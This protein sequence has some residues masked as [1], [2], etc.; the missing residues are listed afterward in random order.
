MNKTKSLLIIAILALPMLSVA[1]TPSYSAPT[2]EVWPLVGV[3]DVANVFYVSG[4][5]FDP[6]A[7]LYL[8]VGSLGYTASYDDVYL[9]AP[10]WPTGDFEAHVPAKARTNGAI[11][12]FAFGVVDGTVFTSESDQIVVAHTEL[13]PASADRAG[14][15]ISVIT[16][17][18]APFLTLV[19]PD[20]DITIFHVGDTITIKG[21]GFT[22]EGQVEIYWNNPNNL[23]ATTTADGSGKISV[24]VTVP[25][26]PSGYM[27]LLV[28]DVEAG[29]LAL[30]VYGEQTWTLIMVEPSIENTELSIDGSTTQ[31]FGVI[32]HGFAAINPDGQDGTPVDKAYQPGI[33]E[34]DSIELYD[35]WV[36]VTTEHSS[37]TASPNGL[38][39]ISRVRLDE[40]LYMPGWV[41]EIVPWWVNTFAGQEYP[42]YVVYFLDDYVYGW[43]LFSDPGQHEM[44]SFIKGTIEDYESGYVGDTFHIWIWNFPAN[45]AV[46]V[47]FGG[48]T[49][50]TVINTD[51]NGAGTGTFEVPEQPGGEYVVRAFVNGQYAYLTFEILPS[52]SIDKSEEYVESGTTITIT[53]HGLD[54]DWPYIPTEDGWEILL[55][56]D[57]TIIAGSVYDPE[58]GEVLPNDLGTII[59]EYTSFYDPDDVYTGYEIWVELDG[60]Y[61]LYYAVTTPYLYIDSDSASVCFDGWDIWISVYAG[62][63]PTLLLSDY[64]ET[65]VPGWAYQVLLDGRAIKLRPVGRNYFYGE[66]AYDGLEFRWNITSPGVHKMEVVK[67]ETGE[68]VWS[69]TVFVSKP[70]LTDSMQV[71]VTIA[72]YGQDITIY[73]W[74]FDEYEELDAYLDCVSTYYDVG[75]WYGEADC[76]G[77]LILT[78]DGEELLIPMGDYELWIYQHPELSEIIT[79]LPTYEGPYPDEGY[80][81]ELFDIYWYDLDPNTRY[82]LWFGIDPDTLT[83]G[84]VVASATSDYTGYVE[85]YEVE[86]PAV[87]PGTYYIGI[88]RAGETT[89]I[90]T[91]DGTFPSFDVENWIDLTPMEAIPGQ[92][93]KFVWNEEAF[94]A[95]E[96]PIWVTVYING[97]PY[98]TVVAE[99][100]GY[101]TLTGAF[102]MTN[103]EAG[104]F[105]SIKLRAVDILGSVVES[106][107]SSAMLRAQGAGALMLG[108]DLLNDIAYIKGKVTTIETSL[109][110]LDAKVVGIS[111]GIAEIQTTLGTM[112]AK[113]Q[114]LNAEVLSITDDIAEV[115]TD[116]GTVK[117]KISDVASALASHDE[118]VLA[119]LDSIDS[120]ISDV[121]ASITTLAGSISG[122]KSDI[123]AL[124]GDISDVKSAVDNVNSAVSGL[125]SDIAGVK[126]DVAAVKADTAGLSNISTFVIIAAILA[127]ITVVLEIVVLAR[128]K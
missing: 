99:W 81:A 35:G 101:S 47:M 40:E 28:Y 107:W 109:S 71:D 106:S 97:H 96:E 33:I 10:T 41:E 80:V 64:D 126:S 67:K 4:G 122:V 61:D 44:A 24:D 72:T 116:L 91:F 123:A 102:P 74:N 11:P 112:W 110:E 15:T 39:S 75:P 59:I 29:V 84:Q 128:K 9:G 65:L 57:Y 38:I 93:V 56:T 7:A 21:E 1:V 31:T 78:V 92:T 45:T 3:Q 103:G 30:D 6:G 50:D 12:D 27:A 77:A 114:D 14:Q 17:A 100:D 69:L 23:I 98:Y 63:T 119:K 76:N 104:E 55:E 105:L 53:A 32:G 46:T 34:E 66:E 82:D 86:V 54:P 8:Y 85:F 43:K 94:M 90:A 108:A 73:L 87:L 121:A 125:K 37:A 83:G 13:D 60:L 42:S 118:A 62:S 70:T 19:D 25:E 2:V 111:D 52:M 22:I 79:I 5:G 95:M 48:I 115:K 68:V 117:A 20:P 120:S 88:S 113:I 124:K 58:T 18:S 51:R 16:Y 36:T 127:A 89:I 49:Y 26:T